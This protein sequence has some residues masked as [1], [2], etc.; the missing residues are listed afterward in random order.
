MRG[1]GAQNAV[2]GGGAQ[3]VERGGGVQFVERG[4]GVQFAGVVSLQRSG[5][6]CVGVQHKLSE[7][8]CIY[9]WMDVDY[10]V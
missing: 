6:N 8:A 1:G 5:W 9:G 4:G 3:F 7:R 2:R 10:K